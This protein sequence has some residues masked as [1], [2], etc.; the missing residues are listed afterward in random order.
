MIF[1]TLT[2]SWIS[3][4]AS[5]DF[6]GIWKWWSR[7]VTFTDRNCCCFCHARDPLFLDGVPSACCKI[8]SAGCSSGKA[9][10]FDTTIWWLSALCLK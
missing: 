6:C 4:A 7:S 5:S 9:A 3:W 8:S 10:L 2:S 1:P